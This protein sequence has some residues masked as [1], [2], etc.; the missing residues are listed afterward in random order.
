MI[1]EITTVIPIIISSITI[2]LSPVQI[3]QILMQVPIVI[4]IIIQMSFTIYK[5]IIH[6]EI[7]HTEIIH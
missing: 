7:V 3:V 6:L 4:P 1:K 5:E 2:L